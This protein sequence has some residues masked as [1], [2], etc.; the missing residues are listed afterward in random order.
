MA[1]NPYQAPDNPLLL[2]TSGPLLASRGNRLGGALL[3]FLIELA[4]MLPLEISTGYWQVLMDAAR[5]HRTPPYD[6]IMMW[7]LVWVAIF[8]VVQGYPLLKDGQTW[9]KKMVGTRIV[10]M[11]GRQP[12]VKQLCLRYL[13][14]KVSGA[15]PFVRLLILVDVLMVYRSDKRCAHD[16]AA[17]TQ[18]IDVSAEGLP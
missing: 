7:G 8:L 3:D 1:E 2:P 18:V 5:E 16:L 9:G 11:D 14:F 10:T 6:Q 12:S 4:I 13:P 17:G 15:I